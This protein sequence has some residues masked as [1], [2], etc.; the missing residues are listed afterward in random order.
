VKY[1]LDVAAALREREFRAGRHNPAMPC[2]D[3]PI[4]TAFPAP[5]PRHR[6]IDEAADA[7]GTRPALDVVGVGDEPDFA[8]ACPPDHEVP[9][10]PYET[11]EPGLAA[12][13]GNLGVLGDVE[14]GHAVYVV[15]FAGGTPAELLFAGYSYDGRRAR[16]PHCR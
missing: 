1:D 3:F 9:E 12:V 7:D 6:T 10:S 14:R 8:A 4:T 15:C 13:G 5:G 2:V 16:R 11:T